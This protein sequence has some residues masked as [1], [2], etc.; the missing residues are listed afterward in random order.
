[1]FIFE[2]DLGLLSMKDNNDFPVI[3]SI[4]DSF[5]NFTDI[6]KNIGI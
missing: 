6:D 1:M 3:N 4:L 2:N 5:E